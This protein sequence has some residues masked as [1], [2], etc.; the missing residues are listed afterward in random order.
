MAES[1]SGPHRA[2]AGRWSS[3]YTR[4]EGAAMTPETWNTCTDPAMLVFWHYGTRDTRGHAGFPRGKPACPQ[5][6]PRRSE[7]PLNFLLPWHTSTLPSQGEWK[8]RLG[9]PEV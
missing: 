2:G 7:G 1:R 6:S 9:R 3:C 4:S 5:P 8:E